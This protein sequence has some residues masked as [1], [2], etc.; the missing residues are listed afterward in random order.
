MP[1]A[2]AGLGF[3]PPGSGDSGIRI[4][5]PPRPGRGYRKPYTLPYPTKISKPRVLS[6]SR[7]VSARRFYS[8]GPSRYMQ[9]GGTLHSKVIPPF[10]SNTQNCPFHHSNH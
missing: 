1:P 3:L 5:D 6:A 7:T 10:S 9:K 8:N 4:P 2:I